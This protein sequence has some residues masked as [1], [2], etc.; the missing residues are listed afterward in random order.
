MKDSPSYAKDSERRASGQPY[1]RRILS[2]GNHGTN[3]VFLVGVPESPQNGFLPGHP[4]TRMVPITSI[5]Y[6][7]HLTIINYFP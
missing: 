6:P 2:I 1:G 3:R 4:V 5:F 7:I